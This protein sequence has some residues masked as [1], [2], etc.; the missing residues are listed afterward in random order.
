MNSIDGVNL[1][2]RLVLSGKLDLLAA[3]P[4][5]QALLARRGADLQLDA[6]AVRHLG[7][8]CLQVLL[9]AA[10]EWRQSRQRLTFWGRSAAFDEA[11]AT[12]AV[13]LSELQSEVAP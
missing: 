1:A 9:S 4:L 6:T 12:F 10:I 13:P 8:L 7:M 11:L 5:H 2:E 3:P